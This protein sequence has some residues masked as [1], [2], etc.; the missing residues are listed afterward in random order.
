MNPGK[1]LVKGSALACVIYPEN[2]TACKISHP[3]TEGP[4]LGDLAVL[5]L[6]TGIVFAV[7]ISVADIV[8]LQNKAG[9]TRVKGWKAGRLQGTLC[10]HLASALLA[11]SN[12][13]TF[14]LT[15]VQNA[16]VHN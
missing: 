2:S 3:E 16:T 13:T 4:F 7:F 9:T 10:F 1:K 15:Q 11:F 6:C 14:L 5:S 12:Q 8:A